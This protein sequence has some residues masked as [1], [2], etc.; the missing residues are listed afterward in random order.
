MHVSEARIAANRRNGALGRGPT[1]ELGKSISRKNSLIHGLAGRGAVSPDGVAERIAALVE[2]FTLEMRPRTAAGEALIG[3]MATNAVRMQCAAEHESAAIAH[4]VR[5]AIDRF[6]EGRIEAAEALFEELADNPR[7]ALRKLRKSPE[8]VEKLIETWDDLRNDLTVGTWGD[9]QLDQAVNLTGLKA[10][11][12]GGTSLGALTRALQGDFTALNDDEGAGLDGEAR[13]AWARTRLFEAIDGE[14]A[15]L[16]AHFETLDFETLDLDRAEAPGRALFDASKPACLA[17]RYEADASR[18]F[19][20]A[21]REF[22][23]VEAEFAAQAEQAPSRPTT[24]PP[25]PSRPEVPARMGSIRETPP[26]TDHGSAHVHAVAA[27][28]GLSTARDPED[29]SSRL[30][31]TAGSAV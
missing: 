6:D 2:A 31:S 18:G 28:N 30:V 19:F 25:V 20:R 4:H 8:G 26:S 16:E 11:H 9:E 24:P 15:G 22:R 27:P 13:Q 7:S 12:A 3:Q 17:R 5:H 10:R 29:R 21:L 23:K 14:I 1:S